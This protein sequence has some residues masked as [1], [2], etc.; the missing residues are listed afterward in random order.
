MIALQSAIKAWYKLTHKYFIFHHHH[1]LSV[2]RYHL[3]QLQPPRWQM[4]LSHPAPE[5]FGHSSTLSSSSFRMEAQIQAQLQNPPSI[6]TARDL[7]GVGP[8]GL[9]LEN[10]AEIFSS[11][12]PSLSP[13]FP[14]VDSREFLPKVPTS[15]RVWRPSVESRAACGHKEVDVRYDGK[16][17]WKNIFLFKKGFSIACVC[18]FCIHN[19]RTLTQRLPPLLSWTLAPVWPSSLPSF[20][21]A[22]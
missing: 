10:V 7:L 16:E 15:R 2:N 6:I 11:T 21:V 1:Q 8:I 9:S 5:V 22:V 14:Q 3:S 18:T 20:A 13:S 19:S 12:S 17:S 4:G